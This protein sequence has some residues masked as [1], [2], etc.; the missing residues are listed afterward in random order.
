[1]AIADLRPGT[2]DVP[3][4]QGDT[5][6]LQCTF[7][8]SLTSWTAFTAKALPDS[9]HAS[10]L[11]FTVDTSQQASQIITLT[12]SAAN[13]ATFT[14]ARWSLKATNASSQIITLLAGTI[15]A[16]DEPT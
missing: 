1:L 11:S 8:I 4:T 5:L 13:T 7:N 14:E 15:T 6:V 3:M 9:P 2:L 12:L 10:A 16:T